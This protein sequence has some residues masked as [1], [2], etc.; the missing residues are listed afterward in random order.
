MGG[1]APPATKKDTTEEY[2]GSSWTAGGTLANTAV[3]MDGEGSLTAGLATGGGPTSVNCQLYDGSSWT[4]TTSMSNAR[5]LHA[6]TGG[7]YL[8]ALATG[9]APPAG[10][11]NATEE[12]S[13]PGVL[14][15]EDIDVT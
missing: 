15:P 2:N 6:T 12:F 4:N 14:L 8:S 7:N 1:E 11:T 9:G 13:G 5:T 10:A 3:N